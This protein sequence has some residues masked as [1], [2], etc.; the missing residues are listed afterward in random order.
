MNGT[1]RK[2]TTGIR[3]RSQGHYELRAYNSATD[4]RLSRTY[5]L[6]RGEADWSFRKDR[7]QLALLKADT[8]AGRFGGAEATPSRPFW[9]PQADGQLSQRTELLTGDTES[10]ILS[11]T[12][13]VLGKNLVGFTP[14]QGH[15]AR[16]TSASL[17]LVDPLISLR[18]HRVPPLLRCGLWRQASIGCE[19]TSQSDQCVSPPSE[20]KVLILLDPRLARARLKIGSTPKKGPVALR[21]QRLPHHGEQRNAEVVRVQNYRRERLRSGH[22]PGRRSTGRR[23]VDIERKPFGVR[24]GRA[25]A[26][27][28]PVVRKDR[29]RSI[30][31]R[32]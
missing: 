31:S 18:T 26:V 17:G 5:R 4:S 3:E 27:G 12:L 19:R 25:F 20:V 1:A 14:T 32:K 9:K 22:Y 11:C 10:R 24:T 13:T 28:V 8:V 2:P 29:D 7:E 30:L 23:F 15:F 21:R 16:T 6:P